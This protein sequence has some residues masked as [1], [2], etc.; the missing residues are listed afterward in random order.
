MNV[1]EAILNEVAIQFDAAE[2][3]T[4]VKN[5][6]SDNGVTTREE[7]MPD[8]RYSFIKILSPDFA[9][10]FTTA[11]GWEVITATQ[12]INANK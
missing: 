1:N 6:L 7:W 4:T 8:D 9:E 3:C 5:I 12:F 11:L 10:L 2:Q